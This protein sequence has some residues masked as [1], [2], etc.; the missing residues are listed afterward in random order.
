M[1]PACGLSGQGRWQA[2]GRPC[3]SAT[4][5]HMWF[6]VQGHAGGAPALGL[7]EFKW[8]RLYRSTGVSVLRNGC[9]AGI[10]R[11]HGAVPRR[12]AACL[13]PAPTPLY[14]CPALPQPVGRQASRLYLDDDDGSAHLR[15]GACAAL[16]AQPTSRPVHRMLSSMKCPWR[17]D[18]K[19]KSW[20][21]FVLFF[22]VGGSMRLAPTR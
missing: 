15:A 9:L 16:A 22:W 18:I 10:L 1:C 5:H 13:P 17:T 6:E 14:F 7:A 4:T 21:H 20:A 2:F 11:R 3:G 19:V 12:A 8:R